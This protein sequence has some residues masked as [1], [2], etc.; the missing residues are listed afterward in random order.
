MPPFKGGS[1]YLTFKRV[2]ARKYRLPEG[3]PPLAASLIGALCMLEPEERLGGKWTAEA[4]AVDPATVKG[5]A[6]R[7]LGGHA[8]IRAH[9]FFAPLF[10]ELGAA[11][12]LHK[13]PVP[14][15]LE[16]ELAL[17]EQVKHI[18]EGGGIRSLGEEPEIRKALVGSWSEEKRLALAFE[19][20]KR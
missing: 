7:A 4:N 19:C 14:K 20:G 2:L 18:A 10:A 12:G 5:V 6:P 1:D 3:T 8:E 11:T 16:A 9:P 17:S 13:M 15:I